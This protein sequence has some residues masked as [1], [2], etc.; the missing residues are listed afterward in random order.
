MRA[1][2]LNFKRQHWVPSAYFI[3]FFFASN[4]VMAGNYDVEMKSISD[5]VTLSFDGQSISSVAVLDFTDL[6][7]TTTELG[8]FLSE[9]LTINL[10]IGHKVLNVVD[11]ANLSRLLDE[12][13]L[14]KSG[15]VNPDDIKKLGK[16]AG[17]DALITGTVTPMGKMLRISTKVINTETAKI[18][19][20]AKGNVETTPEIAD[21]MRTR[22]ASEKQGV[23]SSEARIAHPAGQQKP[24]KVKLEQ[25]LKDHYKIS[26]GS[27]VFDK[28]STQMTVFMDIENLRGNLMCVA[29]E[30]GGQVI[31]IDDYAG[32]WEFMKFVGL[33]QGLGRAD[34]NGSDYSKVYDSYATIPP[35][36]T[37]RF[38]LVIK[39]VKTEMSLTLSDLNFAL[40]LY[41]NSL[42]C[43]YPDEAKQVNVGFNGIT[44]AQ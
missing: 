4:S 40:R 3:L 24:K 43:R 2:R 15:L 7:G 23:A 41:W 21:L 22:V 17:V 34:A 14:S 6:Q 33:K 37:Q 13:K 30:E 28:Q 27:V 18:V 44:A 29:T 8:R 5:S 38:A 19:G 25:S 10:V 9:E 36:E 26:V 12:H 31:A 16:I 1:K 39:P 11:R 42:Y 35:T 32:R 20:A